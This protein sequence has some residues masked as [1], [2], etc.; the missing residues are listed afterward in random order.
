[1]LSTF[2]ITIKNFLN[3][4]QIS[5]WFF[6]GFAGF[7]LTTRSVFAAPAPTAT[8]TTF[9]G[10]V[11]RFLEI[12]NLVVP[13]IFAAV[14]LVIVWKIIDAWVINGG[15]AT[16]RQEGKQLVMIGVIV[17]VLMIVTWGIVALLRT[18]FFG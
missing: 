3:H 1:M 17:F 8:P 7:L 14:F 16:K 2:K 9:A 11:Q 18:T 12:I 15:D 5:A 10:L 6:G 4:Q 13:L